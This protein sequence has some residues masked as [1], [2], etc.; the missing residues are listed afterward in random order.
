LPKGIT[1][2]LL[3]PLGSI[4]NLLNDMNTNNDAGTC[5]KLDAFINNVNSLEGTNPTTD[6]VNSLR[7]LANRIKTSI[8][9]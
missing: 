1:Q 6:E 4:A 9:C 2:S 3:A 7:D 5:G 8:G